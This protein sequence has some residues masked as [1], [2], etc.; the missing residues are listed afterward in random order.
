MN[1]KDQI[2]S[3]ADCSQ[4]RSSQID[5]W[6]QSQ[7]PSHW[8]PLTP[9][10]TLELPVTSSVNSNPLLWLHQGTKRAGVREASHTAALPFIM[11]SLPTGW[12]LNLLPW[13]LQFPTASCSRCCCLCHKIVRELGHDKTEEKETKKDQRFLSFLQAL[14]LLFPTLW[15]RTRRVSLT[16]V[17]TLTSRLWTALISSWGD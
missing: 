1:K 11:M 12:S 10:S 3:Y 13:L 4:P 6:D 5:L 7:A 17:P 14:R 2:H 8:P 15:V 9:S 16:S